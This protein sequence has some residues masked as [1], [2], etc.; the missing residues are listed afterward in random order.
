M[1][2]FSLQC[3]HSGC[4]IE[5]RQ[6]GQGAEVEEKRECSGGDKKVAWTEGGSGSKGMPMGDCWKRF[7]FP[8]RKRQNVQKWSFPFDSSLW[9]R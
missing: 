4:Y 7:S 5:K 9:M 6:T 2:S 8:N 1:I 3:V